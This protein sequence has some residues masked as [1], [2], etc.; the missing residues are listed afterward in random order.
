MDQLRAFI[1][2]VM[3]LSPG[4][5]FSEMKAAILEELEKINTDYDRLKF[6]YERLNK[7]KNILNS[8]LTRTTIDLK[9]ASENLKIRAEELSTLLATIPAFIYFKD[10]Q[11][12]YVLVN[13]SFT[14]LV[15]LPY[16]QI[17]G[18]KVR[19][20]FPG[21]DSDIYESKELEVLAT[22][23]ALYDIEEMFDD[24]TRKRYGS[25]SIAPIRDPGGKIIGL[26]GVSRDIT[27][28]KRHEAELRQ[29]K[30]MAEAGTVAKNEFIASVSHEFRTPMNG[31]LG[32]SEILKNTPLDQEQ[33]ELLRGI[34]VSAENLLTL[35]NDV[36]DFSA[37]EAGKM[38][39]NFHPFLLSRVMEDIDLMIRHKA[40]EKALGFTIET[41]ESVPDALCGDSKRLRQV[42]INL[43]QNA[44]KF[45]E[46]G[47]IKVLIGVEQFTGNKVE[48]RFEVRDTGIGI[49]EEALD[50]LFQV[51]SRVRQ[52]KTKMIAGT[53]LG[54]SI[55]K[56]IT[57]MLGGSIGVK[58]KQGIGSG[59]WFILPFSLTSTGIE[60]APGIPVQDSESFDGKTV[61]VAEDNLINQRVVAYQLHKMGFL[62]EMASDGIEAYEKYRENKYD[63]IILDIQMPGMDGYQVAR[64]IR[65]REKNGPV[66][67]RI[68]ALT[69]NAMKGDRERY[70]EAGM[71]GYVTKP[72]TFEQLRESVSQ[73][74]K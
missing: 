50:S 72:F 53:G 56:K 49:P 34:S 65:E 32:L 29:A 37:I 5:D 70:L 48:L 3:Q 33:Q 58:S 18:K 30:E 14:E 68:I 69:A 74:L 11:L 63:L 6:K 60:Q 7:E 23:I 4:T 17:I 42:L 8:L 66:R 71:N 43:I 21:Y 59:F 45:T 57:T 15:R 20:V 31:I 51:F 10:L 62:I 25:T 12:R 41:A 35:V 26:V 40:Q 55:C 67:S 47:A 13:N 61:L 46:K 19:D 1:G 52:E 28:R 38:E 22:G 16:D 27:E 64:A 36:L 9:K 44:L 24:G 2:R 39:L 73:V 54:L